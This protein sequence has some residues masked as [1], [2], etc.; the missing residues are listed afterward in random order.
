MLT[1]LSSDLSEYHTWRQGFEKLDCG[2]QD[3]KFDHF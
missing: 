2:P 3:N 1:Y